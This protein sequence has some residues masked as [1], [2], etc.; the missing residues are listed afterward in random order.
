MPP[1]MA[2]VNPEFAAE[3]ERFAAAVQT[4]IPDTPLLQWLFEHMP[5]SIP[6]LNLGPAIKTELRPCKGEASGQEKEAE[7]EE[8]EAVPPSPRAE[9]T[10]SQ[11]ASPG[12]ALVFA[13][14]AEAAPPPPIF[15]SLMRDEQIA[16][17]QLS[18]KLHVWQI[19]EIVACVAGVED[20]YLENNCME[21]DC[22]QVAK[23]CSIVVVLF[24]GVR[25]LFGIEE[26]RRWLDADDTAAIQSC[27]TAKDVSGLGK[28]LVRHFKAVS[29]ARHQGKHTWMAHLEGRHGRR[30]G[31]WFLEALSTAKGAEGFLKTVDVITKVVK[32]AL[33]AA[34]HDGRLEMD[35]Q[36]VHDVLKAAEDNLVLVRPKG[37]KPAEHAG[38]YNSVDLGRWVILWLWCTGRSSMPKLSDDNY[39]VVMRGMSK[40]CK[41]GMA[42]AGVCSARTLH[43]KA[44]TLNVLAVPCTP[45]PAIFANTSVEWPTVLVHLC[46]VGQIDR[47]ITDEDISRVLCANEGVT[48][49]AVK[50]RIILLQ[51]EQRGEIGCHAVIVTRAAIAAC[52]SAF[53]H[54][55]Q[56]RAGAKPMLKRPA[57]HSDR[58]R[59]AVLK[60]PAL[61]ITCAICG[62]DVRNDVI[63]RHMRSERC[64]R[65]ALS[66]AEAGAPSRAAAAVE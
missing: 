43:K 54:M 9:A 35:D 36:D 27:T 25:G 62:E 44:A 17:R 16:K 46:E 28:T 29:Q 64:R 22:S 11:P 18:P 15:W 30:S 56:E 13:P 14:G 23:E 20:Y 38:P 34:A 33:E 50:D 41:A 8:E 24:R 48:A 57:Q 66:R 6:A 3:V 21:E 7:E 39:D 51:G 40:E 53:R 26:L 49:A 61:I 10:E 52:E 47:E 59:L 2:A 60:K 5:R 45:S 58:A 32:G 65:V 55:R 37:K 1:A 12:D 63:S 31:M 42:N 19:P 4:H